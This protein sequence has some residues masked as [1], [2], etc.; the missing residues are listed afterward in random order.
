MKLKVHF[1]PTVCFCSPVQNCPTSKAAGKSIEPHSN[2]LRWHVLRAIRAAGDL[3]CTDEEL[4]TSLALNP[5]TERPRRIELVMAG[6][7]EDSGGTRA[8]ESG[9]QATVW[10]GAK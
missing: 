3:G 4:Q 8:T 2:T 1:D 9:R 7:V 5:S 6:L 10:K